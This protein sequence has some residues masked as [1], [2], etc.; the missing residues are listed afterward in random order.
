M[1]NTF[2]LERLIWV[3]IETTGLDA[4]KDKILEVAVVVTDKDLNAIAAGG[5]KI[6]QP[7]AV[8]EGMNEWCKETHTKT[9]LVNACR[10]S[11]VTEQDAE[12]MILDYVKKYVPEFMSPMCGNNVNFDRNFLKHHMPRLE[13]FFH[14]RNIDVSTIKELARIW[15]PGLVK[16]VAEMKSYQMQHTAISDIFNSINELEYYKKHFINLEG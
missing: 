11:K 8:L 3:D 12:S 10:S 4:A 5:L 16:T 15:R 1:E 9:G 14:Y 6:Y 7:E 2:C 13:S